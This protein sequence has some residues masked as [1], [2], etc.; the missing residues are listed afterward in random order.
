[1]SHVSGGQDVH[2]LPRN[3]STQRMPRPSRRTR[4]VWVS[5]LA[6]ITLVTGLLLL[7]AGDHHGGGRGYLVVATSVL[8]DAQT[9][10]PIFRTAAPLDR[11]RWRGIIIHHSGA[12]A[13]DAE[14]MRRRHLGFGYRSMGYHFLIGNGNRLGDGVIHVGDRWVNQQPGAHCIGPDGDYHNEHAIGIALIGNGNRRAFTDRQITELIQLVQ[15]LQR[16]LNLPATAVRL[17]RDVARNLTS[18]PGE[19]FPVGQFER[20]LLNLPH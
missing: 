20:Q 8:P 7:G 6:A 12:P 18:S 15:Q 13:G 3:G 16:E 10:N 4:V 11:N 5:F 17:H 19:F 2:G 1:M 14:S 9:L